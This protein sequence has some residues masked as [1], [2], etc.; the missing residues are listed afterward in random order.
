[1]G[2]FASTRVAVLRTSACDNRC[3]IFAASSSSPSPHLLS[4]IHQRWVRDAIV[5]NVPYCGEPRCVLELGVEPNRCGVLRDTAFRGLAFSPAYAATRKRSRCTMPQSCTLW[6]GASCQQLRREHYNCTARSAQCN[7][8][9]VAR[10]MTTPTAMAF[11]F[12][13]YLQLSPVDPW[14][15]AEVRAVAWHIVANWQCSSSCQAFPVMHQNV[16]CAVLQYSL[17]WQTTYLQLVEHISLTLLV[18]R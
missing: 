7:S 14:C 3:R 18:V 15:G 11:R 16:A 5:H 1:M 4:V 2:H 8:K 10:A 6:S 12:A 17:E 13:A 9:T